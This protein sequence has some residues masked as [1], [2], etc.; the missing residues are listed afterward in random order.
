[1]FHF[2]R[3][4]GDL[5]SYWLAA[6]GNALPISMA[7]LQP[8]QCSLSQRT[9]LNRSDHGSGFPGNLRLFSLRLRLKLL[10]WAMKRGLTEAKLFVSI[11]IDN[12]KLKWK[13]NSSSL[14]F[15]NWPPR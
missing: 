9:N 2:L 10:E 15:Q 12:L 8:T 1:M 13:A 6:L 3:P 4:L 5:S 11:H 14:Y 7:I